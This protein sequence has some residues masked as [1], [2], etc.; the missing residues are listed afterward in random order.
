MNKKKTL[1]I[2]AA[3][4]II[5]LILGVFYFVSIS[6]K[7]GKEAGVTSPETLAEQQ[8]REIEELAR[9]AKMNPLTPEEQAQQI[10]ELE[11]LRQ[12]SGAQNLT[13]EEIQRRIEELNK[14]RRQ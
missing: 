6:K 14:L 12:K 13:D 4:T 3:I 8:L 5:L 10:K 11:N 9:K 7:K 1:I 2:G